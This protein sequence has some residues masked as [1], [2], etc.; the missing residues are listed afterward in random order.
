MYV[1]DLKGLRLKDRIYLVEIVYEW[2]CEW[3]CFWLRIYVCV[4]T[5]VCLQS[6]IP[7]NNCRLTGSHSCSKVKM[8][9]KNNAGVFISWNYVIRFFIY[10]YLFFFLYFVFQWQQILVA[11]N[12]RDDDSKMFFIWDENEMQFYIFLFQ[13]LKLNV[14]RIGNPFTRTIILLIIRS[15]IFNGNDNN[16]L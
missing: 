12:G 13:C 10:F 11:L 16:V 14:S 5:S 7:H 6:I 3:L 2:L 1:E 15:N 4:N 9:K 8:S